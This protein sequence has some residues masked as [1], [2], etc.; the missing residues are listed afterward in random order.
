MEKKPS[1]LELKRSKHGENKGNKKRKGETKGVF[2]EIKNELE[3]P[4]IP[5]ETPEKRG[6]S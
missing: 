5:P 2:S 1:L 6:N 3:T 4:F